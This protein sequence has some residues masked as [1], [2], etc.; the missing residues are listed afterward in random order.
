MR[1]GKTPCI[2]PIDSNN[3][4]HAYI[5]LDPNLPGRRIFDRA[6]IAPDVDPN[7]PGFQG[8]R[9]TGVFDGN[10]H[11]ISHLTIRGVNSLGLLGI[12]DS[13]AK[14]SHLGIVPVDVK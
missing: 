4:V 13:G 10:G 12:L 14:I 11:V 8:E 9:F 3:G 6:V 1:P 7:K 2:R 5:D